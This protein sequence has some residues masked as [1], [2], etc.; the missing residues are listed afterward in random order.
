MK[1]IKILI[2]LLV[3][4]V[5]SEDKKVKESY[6]KTQKL[7]NEVNFLDNIKSDDP[8]VQQ[9]IDRLKKQFK[10]EKEAINKFYKQK[11]E[12]LKKQKK[13]EIKQLKKQFKKR[14]GRLKKEN[15]NLIKPIKMKPNK[16]KNK[17]NIYGDRKKIKPIKNK[18]SFDSFES[19]NN[20]KEVDNA[21]SNNM[22]EVN[23]DKK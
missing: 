5:F 12:I 18:K 1:K 23:K 15:P 2:I 11:H 4:I 16:F 19:K 21:K 9:Q 17:K 22:N 8:T 14:I 13:D 6:I 7:K 20:I 10:N 3:C